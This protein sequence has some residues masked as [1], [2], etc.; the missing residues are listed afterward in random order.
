MGER[1]KVV[2]GVLGTG[3]GAEAKEQVRGGFLFSDCGVVP[4][5][6]EMLTEIRCRLAKA[7]KL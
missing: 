1:I 4:W 6:D 3:P 2:K 5:G 7:V